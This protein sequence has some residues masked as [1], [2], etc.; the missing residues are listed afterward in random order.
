MEMNEEKKY[1]LIDQY[2]NGELTGRSLDNFK[3]ML[4][5]PEFAKQVEVQRQIM[6]VIK[7]E[8]KTELK[9][10]LSESSKVQYFQN[11]WGNTWTYASA[12]I[13]VL[14]VSAFFI[15][16]KYNGPETLTPTVTVESS[17]EEVQAEMDTTE[18]DSNMVAME[19]TRPDLADNASPETE[20]IEEE[21]TQ[22][23]TE[24]ISDEEM[25]VFSE[26]LDSDVNI[27]T[28]RA[29]AENVDAIPEIKKDQIISGKKFTVVR[30]TPD[31]GPT[32][33]KASEV[34]DTSASELQYKE[35]NRRSLNVE[36]WKSPV[37]FKGYKYSSDKLILYDIDESTAIAFK[38]LDNRLYLSLDGNYYHLEK[39]S[40]Y[41]KFVAVTNKTLLKVLND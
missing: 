10:L 16:K 25:D 18:V 20:S 36:F 27:E 19:E 15:L 33:A 31:F 30:M 21:L 3:A 34:D 41:N 29:L 37:G 7:E 8:R 23:E 22:E 9:R 4:K 26:E 2:L 28:E 38:E 5:D 1:H 11:S 13:V 40:T 14:F 17:D 32:R 6:E 39:N 35:V 12:A 24:S